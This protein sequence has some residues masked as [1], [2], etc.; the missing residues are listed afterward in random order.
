VNCARGFDK[1]RRFDDLVRSVS[2][3]T[4]CTR[5][6]GRRKVLSAANG[7]LNSKVLFVA[8][9]P[10]RLGADRTGIPLFGDRTGDNFEALLGNVSWKRD[11]VFITNAVLCNPQDDDGTNGTPTAEELSNCSTYLEMTIALTAPELVVTLGAVALEALSL[12]SPHGLSLRD[13]VATAISWCGMR[14]VPLYHPGPRA[15]VHRSIARQRADFMLLAKMV[16]PQTGL[17]QRRPTKRSC[18]TPSLFGQGAEPLQQAARAL[19]QL[20]GR[21]TYFKLTKLLY[22]VDLAAVEQFGQTVAAD[23]YLRQVDGPWAPKLDKALKEMNGFEIRR[24]FSQ[25]MPVVAIG[26]S[27]R[28]DVQL[29]DRALDL[30]MQVYTRYGKLNNAEIKAAVY[31]TAPMQ[32][33]LEREQRGADMRNKAILCRDHTINEGR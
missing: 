12:I 24:F 25:R 16:H 28:S 18:S 3:C 17:I 13:S 1:T 26:P 2:H 30:I 6:C 22:L 33:V 11:D 10:G 23:V 19:L 31:R 32:F 20:A 5:L 9:A 14:L 29:D 4:L 15:M 7:N 27:P 8:E 21:L